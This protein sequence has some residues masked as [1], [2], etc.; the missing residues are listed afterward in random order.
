MCGVV[1]FIA[2]VGVV[3]LAVSFVLGLLSKWKILEW[4]Q[5]HSPNDFV[6]E[7]VSCKFC[8]SF[9]V[10][11][12]LCIILA[13]FSSGWLFLLIPFCSTIIARELW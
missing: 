4:L 6:L 7:L 12:L 5:V 10:S 9:W 3:A 1:D 13:L 8:L 11:L 2:W